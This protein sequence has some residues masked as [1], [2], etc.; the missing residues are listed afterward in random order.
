MFVFILNTDH[1]VRFASGTHLEPEPIHLLKSEDPS[2]PPE[3]HVGILRNHH[4]YSIDIPIPHSMGTEVSAR[5]METNIHFTV[6]AVPETVAAK[7]EREDGC[8]Y[9]ST[10]KLQAKTIKDG[11]VEEKIELFVE[12]GSSMEV[13]VTAKV[14]KTNQ[15]NPVLKEGV[16]MIS[17]EHGD[18]S[19][20]T[21]WPGFSKNVDEEND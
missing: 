20:F 17:H 15:G 13:L 10:V 7:A 21:E 2:I 5:H 6:V 8:K 14:L 16:H 12:G 1:H 18:D 4:T 11:N 19:D 9:V 3:A